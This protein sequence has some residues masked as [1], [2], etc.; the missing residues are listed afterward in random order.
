VVGGVV[1]NDVVRMEERFLDD[2]SDVIVLGQ[3]IHAGAVAAG[4]YKTGEAQLRKMLGHR[5]RLRADVVSEPVHG[6]LPVQQ[7]PHDS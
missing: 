5:R 4:A 3:V 1:S 6:V 2:S 7:R